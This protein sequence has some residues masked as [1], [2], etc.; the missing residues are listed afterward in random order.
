MTSGHDKAVYTDDDWTDLDQSLAVVTAYNSAHPSNQLSVKLRIF[1]GKG[2]PTWAKQLGGPSITLLTTKQKVPGTFGRWW[3]PQY[4]QAWSA[5]QHAMSIRYDS[6]PLILATAVTSCSSST[7]EPFVVSVNNSNIQTLDKAGWSTQAQ[8]NCIQ[9][10]FSDY[11]GW[12]KTSI[13]LAA[14]PLP[15]LVNGKITSNDTFT[16]QIIAKCISSYSHGGPNCIIGNNDLSDI[17]TQNGAAPV[18]TEISNLWNE[19]PGTFTAYFQ[20]VGPNKLLSCKSINIAITHHAKSVELWPP[21]NFIKGFAAIPLSTLLQ[22]NSGLINGK[23][24]RC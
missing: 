24:V 12:K 19:A 8:E 18:Y 14:N 21:T 7:G 11:S 10:I 1:S 17:V 22:W 3:T 4:D 5:F 6:N 2:A 9:N 20:T 15:S 23:Q 16:N 13:D